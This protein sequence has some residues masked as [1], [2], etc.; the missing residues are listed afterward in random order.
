MVE[1]LSL[2]QGL[3][4]GFWDLVL[5]LAPRTKPVSPSACV[6]ASLCVSLMNE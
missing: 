6:S 2:A 3:I 1:Y 4:P 5:Y